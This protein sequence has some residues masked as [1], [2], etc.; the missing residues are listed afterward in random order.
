MS[1][2]DYMQQTTTSTAGA[3]GITMDYLVEQ[4]DKVQECASDSMTAR[5]KVRPEF[6]EYLKTTL[7]GSDK[8]LDNYVLYGVPV[9]VDDTLTE[10]YELIRAK[11]L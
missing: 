8:E 4:F 11:D 7:K 1:I 10:N 6:Y 3:N 5:V 9:T 2:K